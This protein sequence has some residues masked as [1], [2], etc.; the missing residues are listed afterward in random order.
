MKRAVNGILSFHHKP[1]FDHAMLKFA[2]PI[3][4]DRSHSPGPAAGK[5]TPPREQI[6][7]RVLVMDDE[8][9][10]LELTGRML[11]SQRYEV[12]TARDAGT[13]LNLYRTAL[14]A[15]KRFDVVILDL[16]MAEGMGGF[17]AFKALKAL[18]PGIKAILSTGYSHE[19]V[20]LNYKQHGIAGLALKPYRVQDLLDA[21]QGVL[22]GK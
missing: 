8:E 11:R 2:P 12:N 9:S 17:E 4:T 18:D 5:A 7:K 22:N 6:P 14:E 1:I 15:G 10:I 21:V 16:T 20:V 3:D 13:A 19:S